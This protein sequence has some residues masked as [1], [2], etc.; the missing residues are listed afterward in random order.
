MKRFF[1]FFV[2]LFSA[3][4]PFATTALADQ[5]PPPPRL[6]MLPLELIAP[7]EVSYLQEGIR[8]MLGSRLAAGGRAVLVDRGR[9]TRELAGLEQAPTELEEFAA[10]GRQLEVDYLVGGVL[11]AVGGGLSLD[12]N[13]YEVGSEG[14][15]HGFFATAADEDE[16]IPQVDQLAREIRDSLFAPAPGPTPAQAP[17]PITP[18]TGQPSYVAPHPQRQLLESRA[19]RPSSSLIRPTTIDRLRGDFKSHDISLDLQAMETADVTGD[20]EM[21]VILAGRNRV[22]VYRRDQDR[23]V[24]M[25][26]INTL[27]RYP[28]HYLSAADLN[29]NGRAEIYISAADL[30]RP[31]SLVIEWNGTD[32]VR[33][34]DNLPWY[35]RAMRLPGEGMTL[36]G[37]QAGG[38]R[39]MVPGLHRL[40]PTADGGLEEEG[41]LSLPGR[42]NLFDFAYADLTGNGSDEII[43]VTQGERLEVLGAG[44]ARLWRSSLHYGGTTRHLGGQEGLDDGPVPH[45]VEASKHYVP[46]RIVIRDVTNN[47]RPEVIITQ[48]HP[49]LSRAV[50]RLRSYAS[51]EIH[52]LRWDGAGMQELWKTHEIEGYIADV[53][54]GPD[55]AATDQDGQGWRGAEL[56]VGVVTKAGG[57]GLFSSPT[58]AIHVYPVEYLENNE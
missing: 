17:A 29:R 58:S 18:E 51:G 7:Q 27:S 50:G 24:R 16:V 54:L 42:L 2:L 12:I 34:H 48:N 49:S 36:V 31:N 28:I 5:E 6:G 22:E 37:Q 33:T 44:G 19:P 35:L 32:F 53:Q 55:L 39:F 40:H 9:L 3:L 30:N 25:G 1:L 4:L 20:G 11:T 47:G 14:K 41:R 52:A 57:F 45:E 13:V 38:G 15:A 26:T 46:S 8:T 21:E 10:L 56:Y 43:T 23:F